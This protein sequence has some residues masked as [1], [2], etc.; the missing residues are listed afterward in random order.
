MKDRQR[1]RGLTALDL[2]EEAVHLLRT[3]PGGVLGWY[4]FGA[5]PFVMG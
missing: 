5:M 3:A 2:L 1:Q 4:F